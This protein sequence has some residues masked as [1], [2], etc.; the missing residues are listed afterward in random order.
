MHIDSIELDTRS[1][2]IR[3]FIDIQQLVSMPNPDI[4]EIDRL[5]LHG[6]DLAMSAGSPA[7][8][9]PEVRK[10]LYDLQYV[11]YNLTRQPNPDDIDT[12]RDFLDGAHKALTGFPA[13]KA[14]QPA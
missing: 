8:K 6:A 9:N 1:E 14:R 3:T 7:M 12:A 5:C 11:A 4:Q 13:F 10:A 2:I